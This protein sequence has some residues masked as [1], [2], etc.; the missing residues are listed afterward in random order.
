MNK[1]FTKLAYDNMKKIKLDVESE[2]KAT[3]LLGRT[4]SKPKNKETLE[5]PAVRV[6]RYVQIIKQKREELKD[7]KS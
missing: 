4:S 1:N 5:Q 6:A 3:G 2:S 7:A